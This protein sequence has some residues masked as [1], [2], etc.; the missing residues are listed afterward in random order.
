M[1]KLKD[2]LVDGSMKIVNDLTLGGGLPTRFN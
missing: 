1:S 2:T